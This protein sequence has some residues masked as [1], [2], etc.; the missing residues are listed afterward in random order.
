MY[1]LRKQT[2]LTKIS[3]RNTSIIINKALDGV[4]KELNNT[5]N[6]CKSSYVC[7]DILDDVKKNPAEFF[8]KIHKFGKKKLQNSNGLESILLK[9]LISYK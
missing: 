8:I 9:L 1:E 7:T 4:S 2:D 3:E 5:R 6:V